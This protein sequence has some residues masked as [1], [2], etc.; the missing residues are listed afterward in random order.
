MNANNKLLTFLLYISLLLS[1]VLFPAKATLNNLTL[2]LSAHLYEVVNADFAFN[3][4]WVEDAA[5]QVAKENSFIH[6][7]TYLTDPDLINLCSSIDITDSRTRALFKLEDRRSVPEIYLNHRWIA[8]SGIAPYVSHRD[9]SLV[10]FSSKG[11][12]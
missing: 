1:L 3:R 7:I 4:I 6:H 2:P 5:S 10:T 11:S 12:C 8:I 9:G